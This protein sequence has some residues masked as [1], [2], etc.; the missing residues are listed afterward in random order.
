MEDFVLNISFVSVL[1]IISDKFEN[2]GLIFVWAV[3]LN[4]SD[5]NAER[6]KI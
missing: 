2:L 6:E 5:T 4:E 1:G 3:L